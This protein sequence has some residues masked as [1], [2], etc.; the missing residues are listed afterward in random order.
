M[1]NRNSTTASKSSSSPTTDSQ[2]GGGDEMLIGSSG[3][4]LAHDLNGMI[5]FVLRIDCV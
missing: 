5:F 1:G 3:V 2:N 4:F